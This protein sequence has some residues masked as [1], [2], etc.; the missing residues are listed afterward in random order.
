MKKNDKWIQFLYKYKFNILK[1]IN[2]HYSW[3]VFIISI[4]TFPSNPERYDSI[5]NL[6]KVVEFWLVKGKICVSN[7]TINWKAIS[8]FHTNIIV[9]LIYKIIIFIL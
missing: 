9:Y 2:S 3:S 7:D 6:Q 1:N 8:I 5:W 4:K